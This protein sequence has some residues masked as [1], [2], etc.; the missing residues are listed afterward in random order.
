M[1]AA[2]L[3]SRDFS[4]TYFYALIYGA[5]NEKLGSVYA[6]DHAENGNQ[7]FPKSAYRDIGKKSRQSIEDGVT[8]LGQLIAAVGEKASKKGY[9]V[10]PDG[11]KAESGARTALNTLLQGAGSVL[12]KKALVI[13]HHELMPK[14][15]LVHGVDY[16]LVANVHD[17][18][19]ITSKPEH[20]KTVGESFSRAITLAGE[21]L[22]LPVP[23]S[24]DYQIGTSW[25]ET[26]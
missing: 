6:Q 19:Q 24:G 20:A 11:R 17:E 23:F 5:G 21:A 7:T 26:H 14:A 2:G 10:L 18:Q 25:A 22:G 12:M 13:F 15:G 1:K 4:K 16:A 9:I 8:G 3:K